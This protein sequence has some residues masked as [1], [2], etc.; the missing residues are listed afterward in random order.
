MLLHKPLNASEFCR[1]EPK[2]ARKRHRRATRPPQR[3]QSIMA[4]P[5]A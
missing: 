3:R 4:D 5:P 1:A 2:A